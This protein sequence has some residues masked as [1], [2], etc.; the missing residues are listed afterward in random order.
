MKCTECKFC[1]LEDYGYSNYTVEGTD[2]SCLLEL[3]P[4]FPVD[5]WYGESPAHDFANVCPRFKEG[6]PVEIDVECESGHI[7]NYVC[8]GEVYSIIERQV[9]WDRLKERQFWLTFW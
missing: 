4:D 1:L 7:L 8:D 6:N 5:N 9:M 2:A 3:N